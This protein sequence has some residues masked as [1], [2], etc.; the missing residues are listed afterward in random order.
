MAAETS[1]KHLEERVEELTRQLHGN[2]EKL[3]VYERRAT[4][5]SGV[6]TQRQNEDMTRE[7][8]L[9]AEVADLRYV[10][11][12]ICRQLSPHATSSSSAL[13]VAQVDLATA[14]SHVQQFQEISQA[15]ETALA[16]LNATYD[17]YKSSTEAELTRRAVSN[18][19]LVQRL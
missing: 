17:E 1:R 11:V 6:A 10:R 7:Q 12:R 4:G 9:E 18:M 13:K 5:V 19:L 3:A 15:N 8:Q 2:E 16:T 14:R